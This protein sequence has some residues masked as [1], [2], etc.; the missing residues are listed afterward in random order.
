MV[1]TRSR[2]REGPPPASPHIRRLLPPI[3]QQSPS[4][5]ARKR[6]NACRLPI[7]CC[8]RRSVNLPSRP[9]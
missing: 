4:H 9:R 3:V 2:G 7:Y 5:G 1:A 6:S 8:E